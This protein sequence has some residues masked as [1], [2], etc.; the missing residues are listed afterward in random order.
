MV[1]LKYKILILLKKLNSINA[2]KVNFLE[3]KIPN[4]KNI[5][6]IYQK[7]IKI[8]RHTNFGPVSKILEYKLK[9]F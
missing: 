6:K 8:N 2:K 9:K 7:S 5:K 3:N 1:S 4:F